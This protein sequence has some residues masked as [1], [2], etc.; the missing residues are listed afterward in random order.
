[1]ELNTTKNPRRK[2]RGIED[3]SLKSLR[4]RGNKSPV[5]PVYVLK[6]G[7]LN[8]KGIKNNFY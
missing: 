2:Q 3:F 6:G 1:M 4:M 8:L 7:E 5:P